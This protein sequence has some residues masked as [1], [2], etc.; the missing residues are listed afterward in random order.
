MFLLRTGA[1]VKDPEAIGTASPSLVTEST[2]TLSIFF[3]MLWG[4]KY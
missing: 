3:L 1:L 2:R 4:L